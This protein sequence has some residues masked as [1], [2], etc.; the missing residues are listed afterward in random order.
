MPIY[1]QNQV[2]NFYLGSTG[3]LG[4]MYYGN[5][6]V[7]PGIVVP[8]TDPDAQAFIDVTGITGTDAT[9]IN[10]LVVDLKSYSIWN[11]FYSIYPFVGG[12]ATTCKYNL[13][14][15][16]DTN[17]AF[18]LTFGN[19]GNF[20]FNNMGV[21][22]SGTQNTYANT[23]MI[24]ED[25]PSYT[26][27]PMATIYMNNTKFN[28]A[29]DFGVFNTAF[30]PRPDFQGIISY[31]NNTAY[32]ETDSNQGFLTYNHGGTNGLFAWGQNAVNGRYINING[33]NVATAAAGTFLAPDL[34]MFLWAINVAGVI[35]DPSPRR[36][37]FAGFGDNFSSTDLA[38]LYTV[39]QTYNTTL[40]RQV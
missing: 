37:A 4:A 3:S 22:G 16:Q 34:N 31:G 23:N 21:S 32:V 33:T 6:E 35:Q 38:N 19:P 24:W 15:P 1:Y 10:T 9:A 5:V 18:R 39:V 27:Y 2:R 28:Q 30:N 26:Q 12:T 40:G 8:S 25:L 13:K 36:Y 17:A 11:K 14:D 29:Y 20:I 7:N